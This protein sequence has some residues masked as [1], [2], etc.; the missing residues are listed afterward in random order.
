MG[1]QGGQ[2]EIV[3]KRGNKVPEN[4]LPA[5]AKSLLLRSLL[6]KIFSRCP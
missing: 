3:S 1:S 4:S 6:K 2:E 5:L